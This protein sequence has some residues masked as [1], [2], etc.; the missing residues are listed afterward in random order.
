M[1]NYLLMMVMVI[2]KLFPM[3]E[4]TVPEILWPDCKC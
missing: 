4:I 2:Q 3:I 1:P